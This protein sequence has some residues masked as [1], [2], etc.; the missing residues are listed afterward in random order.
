MQQ[1][2]NK[3]ILLVLLFSTLA[4]GAQPAIDLSGLKKNGARVHTDKSYITIQWP[5][6]KSGMVKMILDRDPARP[7][8]HSIQAGSANRFT[9]VVKE[10]D[11]V[12]ILRE[13]KRTLSPSSGGWDV[14]FDKVPTRPYITGLMTFSNRNGSVSSDGSRTIVKIGTL[15]AAS[16]SGHLEITLYN[17]SPLF[18]IAAVIS[19][20]KDSTAILYDAGLVHKKDTWKTIA[21]ADVNDRMQYRETGMQDT[22]QNLEVK[23]RAIIGHTATGSCAVFPAPHQYFYP[24]DEAFNLKFTWQGRN[25]LNM[26]PGFGIG[27]RQDPLG[28]RRYVPW[29]NAPPGTFQRLNFFCLVSTDSPAATLDAVKRFTNNDHFVALPGYKTMASHFHNEFITQVALSGKPVPEKPEFKTVLK[30]AGIDIVKLA[31][32]HGVG[33]PR[34]PDSVRL[35]ELQA[36]FAQ[37]KRLS[38]TGFLLLPGEEVN[39]FYGGHWLA[40]FPKPV[41]WVMSKKTGTPFLSKDP[42]YGNVYHV[43]SKEEMLRLLEQEQG[44]A[45]VA[46]ART[47]AS[48]GYPDQYREADF[49]KSDTYLGAA[50]K[51][52]PADL[53]WA[54]LS[55]RVLHLMD[56]MANWGLKKYVLGESDIFTIT[57]QNEMYAHL[58]VNYLQL[59]KLP[60]YDEGWQPVLDVL[61]N[62]RFFV[63]TG[64]VLIPAFNINGK[65]A[66]DT[67]KTAASGKA[68][69]TIQLSWTFPLRHAEIVSGDGK[70]VFRTSIP[71][72]QTL[73]FGKQTFR[74]P[75]QLGNRKWVRVEVWDVA[76]NGAFTQPVWLQQDK[77]P[78][79]GRPVQ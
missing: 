10:L 7:L 31:E 43:G 75:V 29:F 11:P 60:R 36:L 74:W 34:G 37:T 9:E 73:P 41:Y 79:H 51:A 54:T 30:G 28:D 68:T 70:Q 20:A 17:G 78:A 66:G 25:Y 55:K 12:F 50:W 39:N 48:T 38:D 52:I 61:R 1:A 6:G 35:K 13:G 40:L 47:K 32:F 33:H 27:I 67:L 42:L 23:Y 46:H 8:F 58:N 72:N 15:K 14:F 71:L 2:L 56:D 69:I 4:P 22:A 57:R 3:T 21:W 65:Q 49:F 45:W 77:A 16:F 44:L 62:G 76:A 64:E 53:S 24:L 5:A 18:N 59:K 63:S 19:T 26:V